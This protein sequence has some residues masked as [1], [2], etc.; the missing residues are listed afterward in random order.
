MPRGD[1][2]PGALHRAVNLMK[3]A[4]TA[5]I[6]APRYSLLPGQD[7]AHPT[8]RCPTLN[9][10]E[11]QNELDWS[12][13][14][15]RR[16]VCKLDMVIMPLLIL[17]FYALQL[18]RGNIGNALTDYFMEDLHLT[19]L[20]FNVGQQLLSAGIVILEIPS[21][22]ILYRIGPQKWISGQILA[23]GFVATFQAF[24]KGLSGYISTRF[25]LG[26]CEAGFIPAGLYTITIFY[27]R[28]ETSKRFSYF[29]LGNLAAAAST[30]LIGYGILQ[31]RGV[32]NLAGWQWLFIIEGLFTVIIGLLFIFLFP[33]SLAQPKSLLGFHYFSPR[34]CEILRQRVIHDDPRK[35]QKTNWIGW[36]EIKHALSNWRVY[37]HILLTLVAMAPNNTFSSYAPTLVGSYGYGRLVS[38]ALVSVGNWIALVLIASWG[39]MADRLG[40]RGPFVF[41]GVLLWW[42]FSIGNLCLIHS[43]DRRARY[44][45]LVLGMSVSQVYH[46]VN[47]SWLALNS[48][49]AGERSITMALFIMAANCA[50]I[51]GSQLF[52]AEDKPL[53]RK[54][55][56]AIVGLTSAGLVFATLANA[57]Y[58]LLNKRMKRKERD[59]ISGEH[60]ERLEAH[61]RYYHV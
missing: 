14:E 16:L 43:S 36:E 35:L 47:G 40:V 9:D 46:A 31:M 19:Q 6:D 45:L 59:G 58:R 50:A 38:N 10:D 24:Q 25:L 33:Q 60:A 23:W 13:E 26:L 22:F 17:G 52:Q 3:T 48:R 34:E 42:G 28:A 5:W 37:P 8:E 55:W 4:S 2:V 39:Y 7:D 32:C 29:F 54:G 27:K 56:S 61:T 57:Q 18:D 12:D 44:V 51:I 49:S 21:N 53:Y 20:Q 41:L 1:T 30:G 15:E 11:V